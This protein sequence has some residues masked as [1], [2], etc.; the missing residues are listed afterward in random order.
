MAYG[1][2]QETFWDD[3]VLRGLTERGRLLML[4]L[5][6]C[7]HRNRLGLYV[8]HMGYAAADLQWAQDEV[9]S[10]LQE[11]EESGRIYLD[12]ENRCVFILRFLRHNTLE[13]HKV[14]TGAISDLASI[15]DT[16]LLFLLAQALEQNK[17]AHYHAIIEALG[18]RIGNRFPNGIP[19][20]MAYS[21]TAQPNRTKPNRTLTSSSSLRSSEDG[22]SPDVENSAEDEWGEFAKWFREEGHRILWGGPEP[23]QWAHQ[24]GR[25]WTLNRDLDVCK[26]LHDQGED[27]EIIQKVIEQSNE[28]NTMAYFWQRGRRDRWYVARAEALKAL[29]L[30]SNRAGSILGEM[31]KT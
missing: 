7:R 2:V 26:K 19:N 15:P 4:Y 29:D 14:V 24:E 8:L 18:N 20:G 17:R 16:P 27:L 23:P 28:S 31:L 30:D 5:L 22:A 13:N 21:G 3:P 11:L 6:T 12:P 1:K 9:E 25:K 10:H